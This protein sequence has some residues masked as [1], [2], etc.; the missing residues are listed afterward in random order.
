MEDFLSKYKIGVLAGGASSEREVS[1]KSGRAVFN[2]LK[3]KGLNA[4]FIDVNEEN[5]SGV[6]DC[7]GIDI[8]F[9]ALHGKFGEDGIVQN[10]L[11]QKNIPY[12]G[13]GAESSHLALDK[14]ES[15]MRFQEEGLLVPAHKIVYGD[16]NTSHS[17][18]LFPC[19][20]KPRYEGSSIGLSIVR[21]SEYFS[22]A[23]RSA[24]KFSKEI[25]VEEFV[26][27]RE[28]TVGILEDKPLPIVEIVTEH[29]VYDFNAK[30][31]SDKTRYIVP[32]QVNEDCYKKMQEE[33]LRAHNSL[34]CRDFSRVDLRLSNDDKIFI[35]EVNTIPG[36]TERSLLPMA[37]KAAGIDFFELCVKMLYG[38]LKR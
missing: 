15:K 16:E 23:V 3:N 25:I 38:A 24:A 28:M 8:A 31:H 9:I 29:G 19:V 2:A 30:Y 11:H 21:S 27:G 14:M 18:I 4:I 6:I 1:L 26:P 33:A 13:S 5:I 10:M 35:L 12:T 37:A 17:D 32:A 20:V 36:L 34:G 7:H 22:D